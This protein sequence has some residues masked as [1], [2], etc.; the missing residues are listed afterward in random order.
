MNMI[1]EAFR[2]E[3]KDFPQELL[4]RIR[5]DNYERIENER[6]DE[7]EHNIIIA[8][9]AM[10]DAGVDDDTTTHMLQKYWDLRISEANEILRF[11][12]HHL[13]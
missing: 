12:H 13:N 4:H 8:A 5:N 9:M 3:F 10:I 7:R 1:I 2:D 11:A 6:N